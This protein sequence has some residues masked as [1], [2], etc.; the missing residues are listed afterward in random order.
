MVFSVISRQ[1]SSSSSGIAAAA[2][3][4][5]ATTVPSCAEGS[6]RSSRP[7]LAIPLASRCRCCTLRT[8][9]ALRQLMISV[10]WSVTR[11]RSVTSGATSA[12]MSASSHAA[13]RSATVRSIVSGSS[14][15]VRVEPR[16]AS[17][18]CRKRSKKGG[19]RADELIRHLCLSVALDVLDTIEKVRRN[20]GPMR[21]G[22][23]RPR[24]VGHYI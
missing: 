17:R 8:P 22:R 13:S 12:A 15:C 7:A 1:K 14:I 3:G 2:A 6:S 10:R 16:P 4:D 19:E 24:H 11:W 21:S 18:V 9:P 20:S 5:G 23:A